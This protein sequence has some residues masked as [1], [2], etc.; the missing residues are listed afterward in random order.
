MGCSFIVKGKVGRA[1]RL[2]S[3]SRLNRCQASIVSSSSMSGWKVVLPLYSHGSMKMG[4]KAVYA[5][6]YGKSSQVSAWCH[7]FSYIFVFND[8]S[9]VCPRNR[10]HAELTGQA[11]GLVPP[12]FH[13]LGAVQCFCCM[14]LLLSQPAWFCGWANL[15]PWV[16]INLQGSPIYIF[17]IQPP[18]GITYL[19]IYFVPLLCPY[20]YHTL[21]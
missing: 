2:A 15:L 6:K 19:I 1:G 17:Y 3:S 7:P 11:V 21:V 8:H 14:V 20:Q 16:I 4:I 10:E 12:L 13:C 5:L 18:S 9:G